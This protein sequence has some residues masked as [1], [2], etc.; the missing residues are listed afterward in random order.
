MDEDEGIGE[1]LAGGF[2]DFF[3]AEDLMLGHEAALG[4][5]VFG[6]CFARDFSFDEFDAGPDPAGVLPSAA[7]AAD[8]FTED[9]AGKDEASFAFGEFAGE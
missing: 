5:T 4:D 3:V 9:G 2:G 1:G 8:P 7:G 6:I